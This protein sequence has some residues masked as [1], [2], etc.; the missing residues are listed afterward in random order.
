MKKTSRNADSFSS[1]ETLKQITR[2][3]AGVINDLKKAIE[4]VAPSNF[5]YDHDNF[6]SVKVS[7]KAYRYKIMTF[8][9]ML[10]YN[11]KELFGLE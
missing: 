5:P 4:K 1:G 6:W 2:V 10:L 9:V 3:R 11:Y 8:Y 7:E